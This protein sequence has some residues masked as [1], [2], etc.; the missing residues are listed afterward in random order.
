M[1]AAALFGNGNRQ[2]RNH[3]R[4]A[5]DQAVNRVREEQ[6]AAGH[7]SEGK[8]HHNQRRICCQRDF[9]ETERSLTLS[10]K[11]IAPTGEVVVLRLAKSG[12]E[13]RRFVDFNF[14]HRLR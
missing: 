11:T 6:E 8:L 2:Q 4:E 3:E 5:I 13:L 9:E 7:N 14:R 1:V 12:A 10:L